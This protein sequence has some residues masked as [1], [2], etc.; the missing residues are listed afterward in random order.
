MDH[1][2][3]LLLKKLSGPKSAATTQLQ[4]ELLDTAPDILGIQ[5]ITRI[6]SSFHFLPGDL[7]AR[8]KGRPKFYMDK[9][10]LICN[11]NGT[12]AGKTVELAARSKD[13]LQAIGIAMHVIADTG[14]TD[15]LP[16]PRRL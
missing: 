8:L 1:C 11:P 10:R 2:S 15:T 9:Y 13:S 6:W 5:N 16:G 14:L 4:A 7:H 3:E 12:L